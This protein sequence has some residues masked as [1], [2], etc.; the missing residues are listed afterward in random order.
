MTPRPLALITGASSG[1]GKVLAEKLAARGYDLILVARREDELKSLADSLIAAHHAQASVIP[2]DLA[3]PTAPTT[4]FNRINAD[5]RPIDIL[6]NNAGFGALGPF[7]DADPA[8]TLA[9]IQLNITTLTH[10]TAL[11]LPMMLARKQG[12]ILNVASVAAFQPGPYMA[13]YYATKAYVLSFSEALSRELTDTGVTVTCLCPGPTKTEFGDVAQMNKTSLFSGPNVMNVEPV[14]E[15]AVRSLL[16]GKRLVVPGL[17]NKLVT[18]SVRFL[19]RWL[20]LRIV[21]KVQRNRQTP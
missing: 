14:A 9:M 6:I 19:P 10:L 15:A 18:F 1:I 8:R 16:R 12:R 4:L 11:V 3:D 5:H 21:E 13:V 17:L 7:A 2:L 20:V